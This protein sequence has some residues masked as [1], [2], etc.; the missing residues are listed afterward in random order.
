M[1]V[2]AEERARERIAQVCR[3][4]LGTPVGREGTRLVFACP[5]CQGASF[6][7]NLVTRKAG[8][9]T[10]RCPPGRYADALELVSH[11]DGLTDPR[12]ILERAG[13]ILAPRAVE[14]RRSGGNATTADLDEARDGRH[15]EGRPED[16]AHRAGAVSRGLAPESASPGSEGGADAVAVARGSGDAE[17]GRLAR[18]CDEVGE[19]GTGAEEGW[20]A[21][22]A[23][24]EG[25]LP[26]PEVYRP[27]GAMRPLP[28]SVATGAELLAALVA[29]AVVAACLWALI[30]HL[31]P[32]L[33]T[34]LPGAADIMVRHKAACALSAGTATSLVAWAFMS[35]RRRAER[36][37]LGDE[38]ETSSAKTTAAG[39]R[40]AWPTARDSR[41]DEREERG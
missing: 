33:S 40:P 20:Y 16:G 35:G 32:T 5:S 34:S 31:G 25:L 21:A 14:P 30:G 29:F 18:S 17:A 37:H 22:L 4:Y 24:S 8:C 27:A 2:D 41:P 12:K 36:R 7:A 3:Y 23:A 6:A 39:S 19:D 28:S 1:S 13:E 10:G 26:R 9:W 15:Q 11:F 38:R